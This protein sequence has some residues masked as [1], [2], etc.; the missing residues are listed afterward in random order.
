MAIPHTGPHAVHT[1]LPESGCGQAMTATAFACGSAH[2]HCG[3]IPAGR[4]KLVR[5]SR[6]TPPR[7]HTG[8][9]P[10]DSRPGSRRRTS[11]WDPGGRG[12]RVPRRTASGCVR[13]CG[14]SRGGAWHARV[15]GS[16][17]AASRSLRARGAA[18]RAN[19]TGKRGGKPQVFSGARRRRRYAMD[20]VSTPLV[21]PFPPPQS[22]YAERSQNAVSGKR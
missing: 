10:Y 16:L 15:I 21:P 19:T 20:F 1:Q 12:K 7:R 8:A 3:W 17:R 6:A 4:A 2:F 18:P 14:Q 22:T 13:G 5:T 9:R 11:A